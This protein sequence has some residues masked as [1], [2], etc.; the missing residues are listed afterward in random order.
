MKFGTLYAYWTHEWTGDY[1]HFAK[2][3]KDIGFDILEISAGDLLKM[4]D[5][6]LTELKALAADLG[7]EISSNIGPPKSKDVASADPAVRQAGITFLTD[8]MK[9][10]DKLDSRALVGV[11]YTY[12]PNEF[13]D[14]DKQAAWDRGVQS[15]KQL[16]K[17]AGDLGI[18]YCLE[19]VNRFETNILNT[20]EEAVQYLKDVDCDSVKMLLDTFH[21]NIEEDNMAD[22]IRLA[23]SSLGHV[24]L[25]EGNR[26][27]PGQGSLPWN[28]IGKALRDIGFSKGVVMEPFVTMGGT[29]GEDIKVWRD[30]SR[31]ADAAQMDKNISESLAFVRKAFLG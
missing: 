13:D 26:N 18:D 21:M 3:V 25:G 22:A 6:E 29:V 7:I 11:M 27:L 1:K 15:V 9:A 10:M 28:D 14:L 19:V 24:H 4:S 23:G 20:C 8:I 12:W 17:I 30:I 2:K 5:T 31:G 16:G